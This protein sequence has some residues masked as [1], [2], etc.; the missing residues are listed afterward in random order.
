[1]IFAFDLAN[2]LPFEVAWLLFGMSLKALAGHQFYEDEIKIE[3]FT[4][5][6]ET[7]ENYWSLSR[8]ETEH[9]P[10]GLSVVNGQGQ[11]V[12]KSF[13]SWI[14]LAP[15]VGQHKNCIQLPHILFS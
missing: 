8:L 13:H 14:A 3:N 4:I 9:S 5:R 11:G 7:E 6:L 15:D 12:W 2:S 10:L 1:M